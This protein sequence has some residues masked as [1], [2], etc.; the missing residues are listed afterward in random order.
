MVFGFIYRI[1]RVWDLS[2][3]KDEEEEAGTGVFE[4]ALVEPGC[5]NLAL[6][7]PAFDSELPECSFE[8]G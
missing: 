2:L 1:C 5:P 8:A 3:E 4:A 7:S 6:E